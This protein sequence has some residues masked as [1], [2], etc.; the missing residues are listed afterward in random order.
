MT[1]RFAY[2]YAKYIDPRRREAGDFPSKLDGAARFRWKET[3]LELARGA[4][5]GAEIK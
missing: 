5:P 4:K 2:V 3:R 1:A